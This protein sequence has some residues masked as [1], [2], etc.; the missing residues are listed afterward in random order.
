MVAWVIQWAIS[1][2]FK[3]IKRLEGKIEQM[4]VTK[5]EH[6]ANVQQLISNAQALEAKLAQV[7]SDQDL[8]DIDT[9]V[10]AANAAAQAALNPP[11]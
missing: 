2:A 6:I 8:T 5:A 7:T 9:A 1:L 10:V 3:E 11:A 4:A